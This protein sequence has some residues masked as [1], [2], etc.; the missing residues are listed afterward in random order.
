METILLVNPDKFGISMAGI[1]LQEEGCVLVVFREKRLVFKKFYARP[2]NAKRGFAN[3]FTN[4][5]GIKPL[6]PDF[7]IKHAYKETK[8]KRENITDQAVAFILSGKDEEIR[9]LTAGDVAAAIQSGLKQLAPV[10]EKEQKI[11]LPG[12]IEREK[13]YRA[14]FLL[15][16]GMDI[17]IPELSERLGF[18][19]TSDFEKKFEEYVF[20]KPGEYKKFVKKRRN[21]EQQEVQKP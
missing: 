10:F 3:R 15:N 14:Y 9:N 5:D 8:K 20:V 19:S 13:I 18:A 1:A 7:T 11:S 2:E 12:F 17:A 21:R 4:D 16:K 6:W